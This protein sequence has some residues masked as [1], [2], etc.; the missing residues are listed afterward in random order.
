MMEFFIYSHWEHLP[1][2][3]NQLFAEAGSNSLFLSR[4]WFETLSQHCLSEGQSLQLCCVLQD[5]ILLAVLPMTRCEQ[6]SLSSL[7]N[8][9]TSLYSVVVSTHKNT[10]II[11]DCLAKGL[12]KL[13]IH[14]IRIEPIDTKDTLM[15][16]L[17]D[18][19]LNYGY[20]YQSLFLFHNW[21]QPVANQSFNDYFAKR[22]SYLRNTIKRK[23]SK[24]ER[25]HQYKIRL[26]INSDIEQA[27]QDYQTVYKT[28]WKTNEFYSDF[29]PA[30]IHQ[31]ATKGYLRL[32]IL[33]IE[34]QAIA[35]QIW[36]IVHKK[37][38]IYRLVYDENWKSYSPGSILT[39]FL[40]Q[41]VIDTD[42][43]VDIDFLTGNEKYK[44]DW[45]TIRKER[46]GMV[47]AKPKPQTNLLD[48]IIQSLR[49]MF[50]SLP[51]T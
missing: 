42:K 48:R 19:L 27:V 32:G 25:E 6:G 40:M 5:G 22:P 18:L 51:S 3:A 50:T 38:N 15:F 28:S 46:I 47:L 7:S 34:E 17:K 43:V 16:E 13:P 23:Q 14:P 24:L 37:A 1:E 39:K 29:T 2:N 49:N 45:M 36:I 44:Q 11:L 30:L 31:C 21:S 41:H 26:F 9:F 12:A 10:R 33:Y 8:R 20:Q 35:A 4:M